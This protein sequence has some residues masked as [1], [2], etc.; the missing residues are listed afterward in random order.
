MC[1]DSKTGSCSCALTPTYDDIYQ[2]I[3]LNSFILATIVKIHTR[4][5][6][7]GKCSLF[8]LG[9]NSDLFGLEVVRETL[10]ELYSEFAFASG[11]PAIE[12]KE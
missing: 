3:V 8:F 5:I 2:N 10:I 1:I 4:S 9:S 12:N 11:S 7:T 6:S